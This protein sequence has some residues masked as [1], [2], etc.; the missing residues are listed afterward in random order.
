MELMDYSR[1]AIGSKKSVFSRFEMRQDSKDFEYDKLLVHT[2]DIQQPRT[3]QLRL[4]V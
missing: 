3:P 2:I 4:D 1:M